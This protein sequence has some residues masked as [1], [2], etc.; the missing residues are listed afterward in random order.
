M[1]NLIVK[2]IFFIV[3]LTLPINVNAFQQQGIVKW[4]NASAGYGYI[5]AD[6]GQEDVFVHFS[7]IE[8]Q[9]KQLVSGQKVTYKAIKK[10]N[11]W[12]AT[13]VKVLK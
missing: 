9:S 5:Q 12:R 3:V 4:F 8:G 1:N 10:N 6:H 7:V 11:K 2:F 13:Q